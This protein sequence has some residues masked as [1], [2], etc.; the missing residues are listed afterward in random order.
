M[1]THPRNPPIYAAIPSNAPT[2]YSVYVAFDVVRIAPLGF[3]GVRRQ[4]IEIQ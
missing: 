2:A 4:G 3:G 1:R